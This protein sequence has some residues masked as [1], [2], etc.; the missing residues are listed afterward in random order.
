MIAELPPRRSL[1]RELIA[2]GVRITAQRRAVIQ[3][4]DEA[5]GHLDAAALLAAA[6]ARDARIDRATVYRTLELLKKHRLV[7]ELDLMHIDG[8]KHFY[9]P[10]TVADHLHLACFQCGEIQEVSDP[11]FD[12]LKAEIARRTGF[13]IRVVR[14]EIGG[15][16]RNCCSRTCDAAQCDEA[17][18]CKSEAVCDTRDD[19]QFVRRNGA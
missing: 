11:L 1:L 18:C 6:K 5:K 15:R 7:D 8:E 4:F 9:E 3:A 14:L 17:V 19:A 13:Q 10:K 2:K 16:C 12:R